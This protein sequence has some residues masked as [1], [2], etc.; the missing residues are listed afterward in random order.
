MKKIYILVAAIILTA[1]QLASAQAYEGKVEYQ[2]KDEDAIIIEFPYPPSV[3]EGAIL[4]KMD[5]M[6]LKGKESKGFYEFKSITIGEISPDV[7]DYMIR[8]ER[9]SRKE[10]DESVVYLVMKTTGS[11]VMS[12][13]DNNIKDKAK[14]FLNNLTPK[15]EAYNLEQEIIL[16]EET[17]KKAEK[18]FSNLQDDQD[19]LEK[20]ISKLQ[21]DL[22][23][24]KSDLEKQ[25]Q[26]ISKQ[27]EVLEAMRGKRKQ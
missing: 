12:I 14:S 5:R 16:Q 4:E 10:K 23:E 11:N 22:E 2:K 20:K 15:V 19:A 9:K 27:K 25:K 24:N 21:K 13:S 18:K 1:A 3:V 6:G 7:M 17:V 8:V 26:E